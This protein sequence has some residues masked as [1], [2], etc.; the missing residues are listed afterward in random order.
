MPISD[1]LRPHPATG[2]RS[3][4]PTTGLA[5]RVQELRPALLGKLRREVSEHLRQPVLDA[6]GP[7]HVQDGRLVRARRASPAHVDR[8]S[9]GALSRLAVS[10]HPRAAAPR[11]APRSCTRGRSRDSRDA[12]P[13]C[14]ARCHSDGMLVAPPLGRNTSSFPTRWAGSGEPDVVLATACVDAG[15]VDVRQRT[16][17][18]ARRRARAGGVTRARRKRDDQRR[19]GVAA[20]QLLLSR[21]DGGPTLA[22]PAGLSR[23]GNP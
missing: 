23:R 6:V 10:P 20:H 22:R 1:G 18:S 2:R 19:R 12:G 13:R 4:C 9:G 17:A 11:P 8:E 3:P 7:I 14:P 5:A 15:I 21:L 16:R